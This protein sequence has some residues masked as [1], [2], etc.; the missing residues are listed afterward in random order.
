MTRFEA[1]RIR[2]YYDRNTP[3]FVALGQGG[4]AIHRAVW[5]PGV[6][7]RAQAFHYVED[8]IAA[9]LAPAL[10]PGADDTP[11]APHVV[12]LGCGVGAS[13][14]YLAGRLAIRGTGVT[15]SPVQAH[16]ARER[17]RTAG[18]SNRVACIEGD[19]TNLPSVID[20]ADLA[21]A[22]ES[23]VHGPNPAAFFAECHRLV[24][25]GGLL[26]VCDDFMRPS[27]DRTAAR[28]REQFCRGWHVN[29][30]VSPEEL[31]AMA[32]R[33]GFGH[34]STTDLT[35]YLELGRP[36][37]RV[38]D[39]AAAIFGWLPLDNTRVG[40]LLGGSALQRGLKRGW[41]G[42]DLAVFRRR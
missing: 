31:Q 29:T 6:Q 16:A 42:Y 26:I 22:I 3:A 13:L 36:R 7:D 41:L 21:Y 1:S 12:D 9:L 40:H 23:F 25:P 5:G 4:G 27:T 8:Q 2:A 35:P 18:L 39:V 32:A 24:R 14:L 37:D 34:V 19:Y 28:A 20:T 38:I 30:L 15:L 10:Q 17:I 33:A 11:R